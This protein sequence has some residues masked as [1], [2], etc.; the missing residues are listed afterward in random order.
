[1]ENVWFW[2]G[3]Q[4][5]DT[6][7]LMVIKTFTTET[8]LNSAALAP[9]RPYVSA[10][11]LFSSALYNRHILPGFAWRWPGGYECDDNILTAG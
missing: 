6:E 10:S 7:N 9:N 1:L 3:F 4:I 2:V 5:H 8:P 11:S